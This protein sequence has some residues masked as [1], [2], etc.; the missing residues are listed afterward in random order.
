M[1]LWHSWHTFFD[2]SLCYFF[3]VRL[4]NFE[5]FSYNPF[6]YSLL[7]SLTKVSKFHGSIYFSRFKQRHRVILF[8][9]R[10]LQPVP[11]LNY[12]Q[13]GRGVTHYIFKFCSPSI[14]LMCYPEQDHH[15]T[16]FRQPYFQNTFTILPPPL[17]CSFFHRPLSPNHFS[18]SL[19]LFLKSHLIYLKHSL[20]LFWALLF[21]MF[22][23][24]PICQPFLRQLICLFRLTRYIKELHHD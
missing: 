9:F 4:W 24:F 3:C 8:F 20:F 16:I 11:F 1:T 2:L 12:L 19:F 7:Q 17:A 18:N 21:C 13:F 23:L 14:L 22:Q 5:T 10:P 15:G 6:I